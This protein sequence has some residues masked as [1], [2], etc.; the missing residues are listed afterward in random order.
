MNR[1]ISRWPALAAFV[2]VAQVIAALTLKPGASQLQYAVIVY[3]VIIFLATAAAIVNAVQSVHASRIFWAFIASSYGL[4]WVIDWLWVYYVLV[5]HRENPFSW[6]HSTV[7]FLRP[8]PL[9]VAATTCPHWKQSAQVLYRTTLNLVLLLF[10]WVFIYTYFVFYYRFIDLDFF[11]HR[12]TMYYTAENVFLLVILG[13]LI[14]R[15]HGPWKSIYWHL[16]GAASLWTVTLQLQN[17]AIAFRGYTLGGWLDV[18][19]VA[20]C[21]WFVW[22]PLL[23][24]RLAPELVETAQPVTAPPRKYLAFSAMLVV[25]AIPLIGAGEVIWEAAIPELHRFRLLTILAS[26]VFMAFAF[27]AKE[28]IANHELVEALALNLRFSEERFY[29]AFGSSPEG[30]SITTVAD[31]RYIEVNDAYLHMLEYE[32]SEVVG[33]TALALNVWCKPEERKQIVEQLLHEGQVRG[34]EASFRTKSGQIR[35][36]EISVESLQLQG[37]PC[38]LSVTRDVTRHRMLERQ[39]RQSQKMEAVGQLAGGVAH[40]F[41]NLLGVILGCAELLGKDVVWN[42]AWNKRIETI[43]STCLRGASLT[44]QLLTFSRRHI[45]QP[46]VLN[47]NA[48]VSETGKMLQRILGE[49]IEQRVVLDPALGSVR[50]DPGQIVQVI[51]NLAVNARDA[52]PKGGHLRIETANATFGE[53]TEQGGSVRPGQYVMLAV[54]DT[55]VGMDAQTQ[56]HIFEPFYTTKPAGEGTGLG[57]ATVLGIV[58]RSGGYIFCESEPGKGTTFKIYLPRVDEAVEAASQTVAA[59]T[60]QGSETI[61]LVEDDSVLRELIGAGLRADGYKILVATNGVD[62]LRVSEQHPGSIDVLLTDVI[63]PQMSGPDLARS[64]APRRPGMKVLYIS[65]YTD[66]KLRHASISGSEVVLIQKPFQLVDLTQKLREVLG[67]KA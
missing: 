58:E 54:T 15:S 11:L 8:V 5:L 35:E 61:L 50:A 17:S 24:M 32:R 60:T 12:Y 9:M 27:F 37:E 51:M 43:K 33:K 25:L 2:V 63:M 6:F 40:D 26:F 49:D 52:M 34:A 41:N 22:V 46:K 36:V 7:F 38:L 4:L 64:L 62:A 21:C 31:G 20:A 59:R 18:P 45:L 19:A 56:A 1:L 47:L 53:D 44:S 10:F 55:G 42:P 39:L 48:T 30:I 16:F 57:L 13:I 23:G 28:Q 29:K 66:D 67:G 3:F 65:G 14:L